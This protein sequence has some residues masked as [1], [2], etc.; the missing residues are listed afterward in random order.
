MAGS[1]KFPEYNSDRISRKR[2]QFVVSGVNKW[3]KIHPERW[4]GVISGCVCESGTG[5]RGKEDSAH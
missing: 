5:V 1:H 4:Q 2:L 3:I